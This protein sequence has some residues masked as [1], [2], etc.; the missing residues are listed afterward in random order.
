MFNVY[1]LKKK[2]KI[3]FKNNLNQKSYL[4]KIYFNILT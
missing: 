4:T 3:K 2:I 1:N